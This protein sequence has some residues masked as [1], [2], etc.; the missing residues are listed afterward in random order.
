VVP[1][2]WEAEGEYERQVDFCEFQASQGHM[3][4]PYLEKQTPTTNSCLDN[5]WG[6]VAAQPGT[7]KAGV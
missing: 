5:P 7:Q 4:K 6:E 1:G 2:T 3:E